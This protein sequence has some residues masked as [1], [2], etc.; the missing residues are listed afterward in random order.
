MTA[1]Q[2]LQLR[3]SEIRQRLNEITGIE[4]EAFTDEI[5]TESD[6]LTVEFREVE[7]KIRAATVAGDPTPAPAAPASSGDPEIRER[8]ALVRRCDVG[9][10][11]AAAFERRTTAGAEAELQSEL[12]L[13][14][15]QIPLELLR[16][17][18]EIRTTVS[19]A[20]G[21]TGASQRNPSSR[22]CSPTRLRPSWGS[23]LRPFRPGMRCSRS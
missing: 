15:N 14:T 21:D 5:R 16:R 7:T 13:N 22:P 1:L 10:I 9:A 11:F 18:P 20:P 4:G 19:T 6:K 12:S 2:R 23:R 3:A 8:A 17:E